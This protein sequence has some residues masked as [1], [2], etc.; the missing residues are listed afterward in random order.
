VQA[1]YAGDNLVGGGTSPAQRI[2]VR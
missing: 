2:V 1:S